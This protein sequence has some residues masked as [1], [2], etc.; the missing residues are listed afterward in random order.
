MPTVPPRRSLFQ[1]LLP[2][3]AAAALVLA[4]PGIARAGT[5]VHAPRDLTHVSLPALSMSIVQVS[6]TAL[7]L[8]SN[9]PVTSGPHAQY[10]SFRITNTAGTTATNLTATLSGLNANVAL[11]G[12]QPAAQYVGSLAAGASRTVFWFVTYTSSVGLGAT[13]T[14]TVDNGAGSTAAGSGNVITQSMLSAQA[15]GLTSSASIGAGAVVGQLINLDVAFQFKSWKAGSSFNLQ[16]AGNT[17]FAAGCFQLVSTLVLSADANLSSVIVPGTA[18]ETHFIAGVSSTGSGSTWDVGVR[19]TFKYLCAGTTAQ[20]LPYSNELSGT[21]LKYSANYGSAGASP[22]PIP[23]APS[24]SASF[25]LTKTAS[26]AR[27]PGG[28]TETYTI[29]ITNI[30]TFDVTVDEIRDTLPAGVT[31]GAVTA[32]SGV[33]AANSSAMPATG[34]TG[35]IV[36][37]GTPGSSYFI[38]AGATLNLVYTTTVPATAGYYVNSA[39]A[40]IGTTGIGS[41]TA[42]VTVGTANLAVYKTGPLTRAKQDTVKYQVLVKNLG[43][44]TA[45]QVVATDTLPTGATFVRATNGGT[46]SGGVVTWPAVTSLAV[47][48]SVAD[49]VLI[50]APN[51]LTTLV[52]KG[53]AASASYDNVTTNN[54]GSADSSKV[55]TV[56]TVAVSVTPDGPATAALRLPGRYGQAFTVS[57]VSVFGAS[58]HLIAALAGSPL[59]I[60][61]DSIR[62]TGVTSQARADSAQVTLAANTSSTYT[63]WYTVPVGDTLTNTEILRARHTVTPATA[64]TGWVVLKRSFPA[65]VLNKGVSP[66]GV[67]SPGTNLTYT[68]RF[69]NAGNYD[70]TSVVVTD[71]VPPAVAFKVG[72]VGSSLPTGVSVTA[73]YSKDAGATWTY[74]PVS[75]G[76]SAASGYDACVNR[77][78]WTLSAALAPSA[79]Q[80]SVSFDAIIR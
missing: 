63:V 7:T 48:A 70:A 39:G 43:P 9:S 4:C 57:N 61:I 21:Q 44:S 60:A 38:A 49:S 1:R 68:I 35:A 22:P 45:Y 40:V 50:I 52:N 71:S 28:G 67:I 62:G 42:S 55:S 36:W 33:T 80:S 3:L 32:A 69:R 79:T 56:L 18:N 47:G 41:D 46:Q 24:P 5:P 53:A 11:G 26:V 27:L 76:C 12:S 16:P 58:Y 29:A 30:S 77:I 14:V 25:T 6:D 2:R 31:Y 72:S 74:V 15:G 17:D 10:V 23:P 75:G 20:P 66:T 37:K 51:L 13:L 19:Y 8:D 65:L 64:D 78:R 34:A 73:A 59:Y 54:D